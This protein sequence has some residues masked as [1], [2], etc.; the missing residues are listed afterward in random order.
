MVIDKIYLTLNPIYQP[1]TDPIFYIMAFYSRISTICGFDTR[2]RSAPDK[3]RKIHKSE[4]QVAGRNLA[5]AFANDAVARYAI[6]TNDAAHWSE[7]KK[8]SLHLKIMQALTYAHCLRGVVTAV[9]SN[10]DCTALWMPPGTH[11]NDFLTIL[12]SGLYWSMFKLTSE[13]RH[14]LFKEFFP[15]LHATKK[16]VMGDRDEDSYYLVYIGTAPAARGRGLAKELIEHTTRQA[17][18]EGRACYLESSN[19]ANVGLYERLGFVIRRRIMLIRADKQI[20][21]DIMVREPLIRKKGSNTRRR[22]VS[23]NT[24]KRSQDVGKDLQEARERATSS[25]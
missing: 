12:R 23:Q 21:L 13:G 16:L 11:M 9:G 22:T 25:Q 18:A 20:G 7:A 10:Y 19:R 8:W 17:D 4:Y 14:R 1:L 3:V 24:I 2:G 6:D 15:L 5:E